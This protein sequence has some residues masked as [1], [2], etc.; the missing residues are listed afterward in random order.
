VDISDKAFNKIIGYEV[1]GRYAYDRGLCHPTHPGGLSGVTIGFGYDLGQEHNFDVDWSGVLDEAT[2]Q[3]LHPFVGLTGN[4]VSLGDIDSL[5]GV[6][7][8]WDQAMSVYRHVTLPKYVDMT[9]R[10]LPNCDMLNPTCLGALV[11]LVYN[12]GPSFQKAGDWY[13]E[14]RQIRDAMEIHD[15]ASIPVYIRKMARL[16]EGKPGLRGVCIRRGDEADLFQE[17]LDN[18]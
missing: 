11:S 8:T 2:I 1:T 5:S 14:M 3:A 4:Q 6:N 16:W 17:G 9:V 13:H 18:G 7:V 15:F 10:A 12:R